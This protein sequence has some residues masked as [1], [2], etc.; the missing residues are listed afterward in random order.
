MTT[1]P[2]TPRK[3]RSGDWGIAIQASIPAG[4]IID[5]EVTTESGKEWEDK[6]RVIWSCDTFSL[7]A[8]AESGKGFRKV[9]CHCGSEVEAWSHKWYNDHQTGG[10]KT[11]VSERSCYECLVTELEDCGDYSLTR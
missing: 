3:L 10:Y 5:A 9:T 7:A 11:P 4:T 2:A 8:K 1:F 6:Y